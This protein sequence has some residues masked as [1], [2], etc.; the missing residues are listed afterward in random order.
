MDSG[1]VDF[2]VKGSGEPFYRLTNADGKEWLM[3]MRNMRV[4]MNLYQPSGRNGKLLKS[5]FPVL[6][7]IPFVRKV[8][9]ASMEHCQLNESLKEM[10]SRQFHENELEFAVFYGTP[11]VHQK[12]TVQVSR[13]HRILGYFKLSDSPEIG[14]LFRHEAHCLEV[15]HC[16]GVTD[17]PQCLYYGKLNESTHVF[18]QNTVKSPQSKVVHHWTPMHDAFVATLHQQTQK[19]VL[20]EHSDYYRTLTALREHTDWLPKGM[21][22]GPIVAAMNGIMAM[23]KGKEVNFTAYHGDFT[24]WNMFVESGRLFVFDWEYAQL[25]YPPHLDRYHFFTQTAI[26]ERRWTAKEIADSLKTDACR[27]VDAD[28][29]KLYLVDVISRF[30]VRERGK[31]SGMTHCIKVWGDVLKKLL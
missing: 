4:A 13:R 9:G 3:P 6:H 16:H 31:D 25:S 19:T 21:D 22:V 29:Y 30:T 27:W 23:W 10:L 2:I 8:V 17:I 5:L 26:F 11:C 1:A 14:E 12:I 15:L 24:P 7:R 20:F 28:S 18:V